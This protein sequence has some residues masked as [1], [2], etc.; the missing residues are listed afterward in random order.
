MQHFYVWR[1]DR[2]RRIIGLASLFIVAFFI[3]ATKPVVSFL[4]KQPEPTVLLKG[5]SENN[6]IALTFNISWGEKRVSNIIDVL[7]ENDVQ[8]T[9]FV[10]G[11]W[12]ERHPEQLKKITENNHELGMLG[13]R[14]QNYVE[15]DIEQVR[16]DLSYARNIFQKIGFE[17]IKLLRTP[18][19]QFNKEIVDL[20]KS[21]NFE[22][23]HWSV[24]TY[25]WER[26]GVDA[27]I[28]T[29]L[30]ETKNGDIILMHA[31][32]SAAQ[33]ADALKVILP[34]LKNKNF[35]F[36]SITELMKQIE[37]EEELVED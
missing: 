20:A 29:T 26:P 31:S 5:S 8:A 16:K 12:A 7:K 36:V 28:Q 19:G 37:V 34:E 23:V 13:Y 3:V 11:E 4:L 27:I 17:D 1:F 32:D 24:N 9:F 10:S 25:D 21:F 22:V 35:N 14:Y 6:K 30:E 15:Q 2:K 18:S 33:T